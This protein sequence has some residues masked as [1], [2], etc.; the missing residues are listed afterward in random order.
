VSVRVGRSDLARFRRLYRRS[1]W[2]E[3]SGFEDR[4]RLLKR[5]LVR[6]YRMSLNARIASRR[7]GPIVEQGAGITVRRQLRTLR[8]LAI[9]HGFPPE[10]YYR[11][12]LFQDD[13]RRLA[14]WYLHWDEHNRV[15][16]MLVSRQ[17]AGFAG[18]LEDKRSFTAWCSANGLPTHPIVA[19]FANGQMVEGPDELPPTDLF[20]KPADGRGG[21]GAVAWLKAPEGHYR[22]GDGGMLSTGELT[23]ELAR[24]SRSVPYVVQERLVNHPQLSSLTE[25]GLCTV[26][27]VTGRAPGG[28]EVVLS[29][30]FGVPYGRSPVDN[31]H[32]GGICASIDVESGRVG[33]GVRVFADECMTSYERHPQSDAPIAGIVLPHWD[34]VK[35]LALRA[36]RA[37]GPLAFVGW[38]IALCEEGPLLME[39]NAVWDAAMP[40]VPTGRPLGRTPYLPWLLEHLDQAGS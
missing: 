6:P 32:A 33:P 15:L 28:P 40:Q 26:R 3:C 2:A 22:G 19:S 1:L 37:A 39:A 31:F 17:R 4:V 21:A 9:V 14:R 18:R 30:S 5:R 35:E 34:A 16:A 25:G 12:R 13:R 10:I 8:W 20:A 27:I 36:Q 29:T 38:D 24:W 11:Y 23:T 7:W